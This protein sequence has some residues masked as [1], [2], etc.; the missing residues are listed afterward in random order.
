MHLKLA[1]LTAAVAVVV[2]SMPSFGNEKAT[3]EPKEKRVHVTFIGA[4]D[5]TFRD[6]AN[7]QQAEDV[8]AARSKARPYMPSNVRIVGTPFLPE[9]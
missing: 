1:A 2:A 6:Y 3:A 9:N 8:T 4:V 5:K 7:T